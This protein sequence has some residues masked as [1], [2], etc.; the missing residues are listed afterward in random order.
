MNDNAQVLRDIIRYSKS[1]DRQVGDMDKFDIAK[2][3][4]S[5]VGTAFAWMRDFAALRDDVEFVMVWDE[6]RGRELRVLRF[7]GDEKNPR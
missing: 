5:T 7:V 6:E 4:R 1:E 3:R 2:E